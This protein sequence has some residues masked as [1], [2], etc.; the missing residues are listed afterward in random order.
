MAF[1][2]NSAYQAN[3]A[4][5]N[6]DVQINT[7][8]TSDSAGNIYF[9]FQATGGL[10]DSNG[11]V[12]QSGIAKVTPTGATTWVATPTPVSLNAALAVSNNGGAVYAL[13]GNQLIEFSTSNLATMASTTL[14]D[15]NGNTWSPSPDSTASP[16]IGPDGD[17][18]VGALSGPSANNSRGWLLHYSADLSTAKAPGAHSAGMTRR[19]SFLQAWLRK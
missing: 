3:A 18:Y 8:L 11:T 7:P 4:Q 2:G 17:V 1:Y 16:L 13:T 14:K 12:I 6:A 9:G 10:K 19:R 5:F 15:M